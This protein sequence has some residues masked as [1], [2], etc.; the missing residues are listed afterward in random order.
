MVGVCRVEFDGFRVGIPALR[1]VFEVAHR[2]VRVMTAML[3][4][5]QPWKEGEVAQAAAPTP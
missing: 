5:G 3:K 4:S 1:L 2:L